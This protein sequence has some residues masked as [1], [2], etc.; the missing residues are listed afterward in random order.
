MNF[1][2]M[3]RVVASTVSN[4]L[5]PLMGAAALVFVI[6]VAPLAARGVA[7]N[8]E[9]CQTLDLLECGVVLQT[10]IGNCCGMGSANANCNGAVDQ[11]AVACDGGGGCLCGDWGDNCTPRNGD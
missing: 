11:Y 1:H 4:N 7:D 3:R 9:P 2:D 6:G 8:C 5:T 10:A